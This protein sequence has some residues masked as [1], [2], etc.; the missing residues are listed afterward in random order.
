M[1]LTNEFFAAAIISVG[2]ASLS[3][4][5]KAES[6]DYLSRRDTISLSAGNASRANIAIQTPT[7]WPSYINDTDIP[8]HGPRAVNVIERFNTLPDGGNEPA[9]ETKL[10]IPPAQ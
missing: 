1:F 10:V 9:S 5:A 8:G 3:T 7:P 2:I 6:G 4:A